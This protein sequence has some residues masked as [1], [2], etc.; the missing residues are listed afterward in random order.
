M[1]YVLVTILVIV[2]GT[3]AIVGVVEWGRTVRGAD[4]KALVASERTLAKAE[5]TLRSIANGAGNPVLEAQ[6]GL[7]EINN[8]HEK[9][10]ER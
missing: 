6:I 8:Y 4:R 10:I 1:I 5:R 2:A 9:E 3:A 7:D